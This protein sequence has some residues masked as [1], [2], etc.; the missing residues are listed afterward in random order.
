VNPVATI[1]A[2]EP[3]VLTDGG[4]ASELAA[5]GHDLDDPL[6]S[7]RVLL[8]DPAAIAAVHRDYFAVGA[9]CAT[10]ASYQAGLPGLRARGLDD[11]AARDV[12]RR[13]VALARAE[14]DRVDAGDRPRPFVVASLGSYGAT[15]PGAAEYTGEFGSIDDDGLVRF[16]AERLEVLREDADVVAFETIP[17]RREALAIARV[18]REASPGLAAWVSFTCRDAQHTGNGDRLLDCVAALADVDPVIAIGINCSAPS[19]VEDAIVELRRAT[20]LPPIAYPNAG[21]RWAHSTW[22]GERV[23][24]EA[25]TALAQRWWSAGARIIGGCCRT[26]PAHIA[27]LSRL[28]AALRSR[29]DDPPPT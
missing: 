27:A 18:L 8:D 23:D 5:R 24:P 12:L 17:S 3:F 15:V 2:R 26:T 10:T 29:G 4:L 16:H 11:D 20:S 1:L 9:D 28:R 14:A 19:I 13:S 22:C 7:A 6:W 25:F 21:E